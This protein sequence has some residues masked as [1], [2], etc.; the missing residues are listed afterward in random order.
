MIIAI[1][2]ACKGNGKPDCVSAGSAFVK[3]AE[4]YLIGSINRIETRSTNQRGELNGLYCALNAMD[5]YCPPNETVYLIT[6]S[7]YIYNA[8]TKDWFTN[9]HKRGWVTANGDPV[10]NKD[11]WEQLIPQL[12]KHIDR[13]VV[14][15]VK[16]HL[17]SVGKVTASNLLQA[18][19]TCDALYTFVTNKLS[20]TLSTEKGSRQYSEA[21]VLFE[22]NHGFVPPLDIF[23]EMIILNTIADLSASYALS[24][25]LEKEVK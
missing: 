14:Y 4:G 7:E 25:Y 6:D 22:R 11:V 16:G 20:E 19:K 10:K 17:V 8:I 15:H 21:I 9:W 18:D 3:G 24:N 5:L 13:I 1:D 12:A 23:N 2:G